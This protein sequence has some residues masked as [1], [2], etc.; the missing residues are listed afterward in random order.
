MNLLLCHQL[1][2]IRI[3]HQASFYARIGRVIQ[4]KIKTLLRRQVHEPT[5]SVGAPRALKVR[6]AE[7][8]DGA[9]QVSGHIVLGPG[10]IG[11]PAVQLITLLRTIQS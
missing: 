7:V 2:D 9:S 6:N 11:V 4:G 1:S 3:R 8:R 10:N 5:G